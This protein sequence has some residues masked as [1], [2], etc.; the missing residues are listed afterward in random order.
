MKMNMFQIQTKDGTDLYGQV[1]CELKNQDIWTDIWYLNT[2]LNIW[3]SNMAWARKAGMSNSPWG[4]GHFK[5]P[6]KDILLLY[7]L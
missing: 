1:C 3:I 2:S 6:I 7:Y 4:L 5:G